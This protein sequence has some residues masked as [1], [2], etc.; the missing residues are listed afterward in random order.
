VK[1]REEAEITVKIQE[2]HKK[3]TSLA[4]CIFLGMLTIG[5]QKAVHL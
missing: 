2:M 5:G 4:K 3:I 1:S